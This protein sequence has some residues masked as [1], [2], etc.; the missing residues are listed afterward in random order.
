MPRWQELKSSDWLIGHRL[1][2]RELHLP[3]PKKTLRTRSIKVNGM[4]YPHHNPIPT[5]FPYVPLIRLRGYW[6]S[7]AGFTVGEQLD[8]WVSEGTIMLKVRS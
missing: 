4:R 5:A 7:K 6:I 1:H 8:I 3:S 2:A